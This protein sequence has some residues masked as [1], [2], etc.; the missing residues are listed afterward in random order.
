MTA[1]VQELVGEVVPIVVA[2]TIGQ[3]WAGSPL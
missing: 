2:T 1:A 3:D